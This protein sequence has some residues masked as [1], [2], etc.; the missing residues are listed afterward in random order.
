V[1]IAN[2]AYV[3]ADRIITV[4]TNVT[5]DVSNSSGA[6][7]TTIQAAWAWVQPKIIVAPAVVRIKVGPGTCKCDDMSSAFA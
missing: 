5:V 2:L 4:D 3:L 1:T 6:N 7:F